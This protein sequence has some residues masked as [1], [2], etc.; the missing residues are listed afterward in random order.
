MSVL[1]W[2][3]RHVDLDVHVWTFAWLVPLIDLKGDAERQGDVQDVHRLSAP[4]VL[5][6]APLAI[7]LNVHQAI[8]ALE[9]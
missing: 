2:L 8:V 6:D 3:H 9:S 4:A 7:V 1:P 5:D